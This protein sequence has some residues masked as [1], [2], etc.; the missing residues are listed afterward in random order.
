MSR[1]LI[2]HYLW[3]Y[4]Y[5]EEPKP[6]VGKEEPAVALFTR[7]ETWKSINY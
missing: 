7:L 6:I 1:W 3:E 5:G 4:V 2:G